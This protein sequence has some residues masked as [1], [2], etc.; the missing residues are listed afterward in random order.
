[1][2][3]LPIFKLV[4]RLFLDFFPFNLQLISYPR[5]RTENKN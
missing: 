1:L 2:N 5:K 4:F 3:L